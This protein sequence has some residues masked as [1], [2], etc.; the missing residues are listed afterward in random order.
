[1][2]AKSEPAA[3][4][5][6]EIVVTR[7]F[8]APPDLVFEAWTNP[9]HVVQW[10]GPRGFTTTTHEIDVRPGGVWRFIMHGPDGTD[11]DN[12]IVFLEIVKPQRLVYEHRGEDESVQFRTTVT[13]EEQGGKTWL[14]MQALFPT[15][16]ERDHV[17]RE[18]NAIEGGNQTLE[19]LGEHLA[20][21]S[22]EPEFVIQRVFNAPRDLVWK[23]LTEP[24]HLVHWWGPKGF[25]VRVA[26]VGLRP[27]G[28]FL[29]C[30]R[31]PDGWEMWGK[32]VYREIAAPERLVTVVSFTDDKGNAVRHPMSPTWPLEMLTTATLSEHEGRTTVTIQS[33]PHNATEE[34]RKTFFDARDGMEEGFTGT[35]DK[36][37]DYL[38]KVQ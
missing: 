29:Y 7:V 27:G 37:A 12:K 33:V 22:V 26:E 34:E 30:L 11:Y 23:A 1:M 24:G 5:D 9:Q 35:L 20:K 36:L 4:A 2:P 14:T 31:S 8:D 25:T 18:Y 19:R 16:A 28:V 38:A 32:W 15:A 10:W 21:M 6:R 3:T 17:V 13:F